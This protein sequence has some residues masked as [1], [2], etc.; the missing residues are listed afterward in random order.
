MNKFTMRT[1]LLIQTI[2]VMLTIR[3]VAWAAPTA[4]APK[5]AASSPSAVAVEREPLR[6]ARCIRCSP[7]SGIYS[8]RDRDSRFLNIFRPI[9]K[10]GYDERNSWYY[11]P[12]RNREADRN[13]GYGN[14]YDDRYS[15]YPGRYDDRD[16]YNYRPSYYDQPQQ[17]QGYY[18][19]RYN[20]VGNDYRGNDYR[21]NGYD[22]RDPYYYEMMRDRFYDRNTD[23]NQYYDNNY[24]RYANRGYFDY[25]NYRPYD[26]TYRGESGFDSSGRGYYFAN[27]PSTAQHYHQPQSNYHYQPPPPPPPPSYQQLPLPYD[28]PAEYYRPAQGG[29]D[30]PTNVQNR[31]PPSGYPAPQQPP[32][33]SY[34]STDDRNPS[35]SW[36]YVPDDKDPKNPTGYPPNDKDTPQQGNSYGSHSRPLGGSYL[37]DRDSN[38]PPKTTPKP[39]TS[40]APKDDVKPAEDT[41]EDA[42]E[43]TKDAQDDAKSADE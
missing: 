34:P 23:R 24:D 5:A 22:N 11:Q 32:A 38:E 15:G 28:P 20:S 1:Q 9:G 27:R 4:E 33:A 40:E 29:Y 36:S 12:D 39:T 41:P 2:C 19:S 25:R 31:P 10:T 17:P 42:A 16:R 37:Y 3:P 21:G 35:G 7:S 18:D 30:R 14:R 13:Y 26:E 43:D 8:D 6:D